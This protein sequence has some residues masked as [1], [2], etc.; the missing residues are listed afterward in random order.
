MTGRRERA[1]G[2]TRAAIIEAGL[3]LMHE[4]G[5]TRASTTAIA[6]AAG[7]SPATLFNYFP[8]KAAIV[9]ADDHLWEPPGHVEPEADPRRTLLALVHAMVAS[10]DWTWG[11]DDWRTRLRFDLVRCEPALAQEQTRRL[12]DLAPRLA[13]TLRSAHPDV[14]ETEALALAGALTGAVAVVLAHTATN[15]LGGAISAAAR[16]ALGLT[17]D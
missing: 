11:A 8:T 4:R 2:R 9:F 12:I 3:R 5:Y 6:E 15:D 7:V 10:P 14:S 13:A 16:T 17:G 1:K